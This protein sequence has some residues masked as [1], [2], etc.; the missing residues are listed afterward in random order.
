MQTCRAQ[1]AA[2]QQ[3]EE[4]KGG[5]QT[6][7]ATSSYKS[8]K[9]QHHQSN[10]GEVKVPLT[11]NVAAAVSRNTKKRQIVRLWIKPAIIRSFCDSMSY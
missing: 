6:V 10:N 7:A 5:L 11:Q 1:E 9:Q 3:H 2:K 8:K 4:I